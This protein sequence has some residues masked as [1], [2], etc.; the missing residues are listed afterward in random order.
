MKREVYTCDVV[1]CN[2]IDINENDILQLH[3]ATGTYTDAAGDTDSTF[4][5]FD[6]C[7]ACQKRLLQYFIEDRWDYQ[8]NA[9]KMVNA[10]LGKGR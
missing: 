5:D 6:L 4:F 9:L 3:V 2:S 8:E 1:G 10:F 7:S